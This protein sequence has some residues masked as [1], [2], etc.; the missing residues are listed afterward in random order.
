MVFKEVKSSFM[1]GV[2]DLW[3]PTIILATDLSKIYIYWL[4]Y[5][6]TFLKAVF[7]NYVGLSWRQ[8]QKYIK[9]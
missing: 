3:R 1:L 8:H 7:Y 5:L 6:K 2:G 4:Q 9:T